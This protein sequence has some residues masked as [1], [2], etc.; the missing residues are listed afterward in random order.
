ME[1]VNA[2]QSVPI[3]GR[4]LSFHGL[5]GISSLGLLVL[6]L[7]GALDF[8][9]KAFS[10]FWL[11]LILVNLTLILFLA[12]V[13]GSLAY[14]PYRAPGGPRSFIIESE[15]PWMHE[16]VFEHKEFI[17]FLPWLLALTATVVTFLLGNTLLEKDNQLLLLAVRYSLLLSVAITL[18]IIIE[19]ALVTRFAPL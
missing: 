10:L 5:L 19:G 18:V 16:V 4:V 11:R 13:W 7:M 2:I 9:R 3:I 15:K 8:E 17:A 1:L 14:I 6:A 12:T